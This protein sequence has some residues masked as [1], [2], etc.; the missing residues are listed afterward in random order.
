[1]GKSLFIIRHAKSSWDQPE[2][3][4]EERPLMEKGIQKTYKLIEY[5]NENHVKVDLILSSPAVRAWETARLIA[6]GMRY[7]VEKIVEVPEI[8]HMDT[9]QI[10]GKLTGVSD[11]VNAVMIVGHNPGVTQL[12]NFLL[13]K[14]LDWLPTSGIVGIDFSTARWQVIMDSKRSLRFMIYPKM[15]P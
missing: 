4:D 15:L 13:G 14:E 6:R 9:E 8:Y 2:L 7:P 3:P 5:L 12:A 10:L 11:D 1:M